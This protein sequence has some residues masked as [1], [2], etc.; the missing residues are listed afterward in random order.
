MIQIW[1][2]LFIFFILFLFQVKEGFEEDEM[3][4]II[5][6]LASARKDKRMRPD[7]KMAIEDALRYTQF[8]KTL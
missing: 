2:A 4:L 7:Q 1:I 6:S 3:N 5:T 8:I